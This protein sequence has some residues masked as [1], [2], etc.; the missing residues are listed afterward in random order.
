MAFLY[1]SKDAYSSNQDCRYILNSKCG[2]KTDSRFLWLDSY[3]GPRYSFCFGFEI[4]VRHTTL[5]KTLWTTDRPVADT[6]T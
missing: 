6:A 2:T 4:T 3:I 5:G 1:G